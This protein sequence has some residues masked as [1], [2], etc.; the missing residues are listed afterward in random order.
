MRRDTRPGGV[1]VPR[2]VDE[3][4]D[5]IG[6]SFVSP[7][8]VGLRFECAMV[9]RR[10]NNRHPAPERSFGIP[11]RRGGAW[12]LAGRTLTGMP[13]APL[14]LRGIDTEAAI[15]RICTRGLPPLEL[16]DRVARQLRRLGPHHAR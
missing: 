2:A 10:S 16:F 7:R 9:G 12:S 8:L 6:F 1:V 4:E 14:D 13:R 15:A 11:L 3:Q 5:Q